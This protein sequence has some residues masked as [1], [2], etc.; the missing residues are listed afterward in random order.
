MGSVVTRSASNPAREP[1]VAGAVPRDGSPYRAS[2]RG[3]REG[4]ASGFGRTSGS[5]VADTG[6]AAVARR[7]GA[8]RSKPWGRFTRGALSSA[9]PLERTEQLRHDSIHV[10]AAQRDDEVALL[11]DARCVVGGLLPI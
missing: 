11:G 5:A 8:G 7:G 3:P 2:T 10:S 4:V 9:F 1:P 6:C